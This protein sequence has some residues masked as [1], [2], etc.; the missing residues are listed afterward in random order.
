M[1]EILQLILMLLRFTGQGGNALTTTLARLESSDS[2]GKRRVNL[3]GGPKRERTNVRQSPT[4][5]WGRSPEKYER[6]SRPRAILQTLK[7]HP[8]RVKSVI[9]DAEQIGVNITEKRQETI[10]RQQAE[11]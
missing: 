6:S 4:R 7:S 1:I 10:S 9:S 5:A 2:W 3:L 11:E 8:N